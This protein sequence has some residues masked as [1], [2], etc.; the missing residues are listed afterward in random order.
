MLQLRT[1]AW[2]AK[3]LSL[4]SLNT[5]CTE[6]LTLGQNLP[7]HHYSRLRVV[8]QL[9]PLKILILEGTNKVPK[10]TWGVGIGVLAAKVTQGS[11]CLQVAVCRV[12]VESL[13]G[14]G[15]G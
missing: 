15:Q 9:P 11:L 5:C 6:L 7:E 12:L 13:A 2:Q 14:Q 10:M 3:P 8:T 4:T 1:L